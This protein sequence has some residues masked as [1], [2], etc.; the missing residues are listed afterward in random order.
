M[1]NLKLDKTQFGGLLFAVTSL[2]PGPPF[3]WFPDFLTHSG[4]GLDSCAD[5]VLVDNIHLWDPASVSSYLRKIYVALRP[6]GIIRVS[7][8]D[9]DAVIHRYLLGSDKSVIGSRTAEFNEWRFASSND[10]FFNKAH[11]SL[12]VLDAGFVDLEHFVAGA[13]SIPLFWGYEDQCGSALVLEARK[14]R[15]AH[16]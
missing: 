12:V 16:V 8:P 4:A 7:T 2:D 15:E 9:L 13:G 10:F 1:T 6:G 11:L 14:K 5:V 3:R